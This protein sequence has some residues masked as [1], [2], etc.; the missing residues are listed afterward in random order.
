MSSSALIGFVTI[1]LKEDFLE[2]KKD[3]QRRLLMALGFFKKALSCN[4]HLLSIRCSHYSRYGFCTPFLN[5]W[6]Y[7]LFVMCLAFAFYFRHL[8]SPCDIAF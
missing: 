2:V 3:S 5:R 7:F 4:D 6:C 1:D 8:S